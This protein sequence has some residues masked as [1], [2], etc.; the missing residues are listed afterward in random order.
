[1]AHFGDYLRKPEYLFRPSQVG[2]RIVRALR[3]TPA[4]ATVSL[5]WGTPITIRPGEVIGRAIWTTGVYDLAVTET[6][7]RLI[8]RDETVV[9]AGANIG[10]MTSLMAR[11]AGPRG[12]VLAFEPHPDVFRDL[13]ENA[14]RWRES[15]G[16]EQIRLVRAALGRQSGP[17]TLN[18]GP[19]FLSNRGTARLAVPENEAVSPR[20]GRRFD[21]DVV[22]L[23]EAVAGTRPAVLKIDVEGH[24]VAVLEGAARLLES[25]TIRDI[26]F[27]DHDTV[28]CPTGAHLGRYGYSVFRLAKGFIGPVL[29]SSSSILGARDFAAPS[30]LAT[31]DP[32]RA[33]SRLRPKGWRSLS[34]RSG[35]ARGR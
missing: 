28:T 19:D 9:D 34:P 8:D 25:G 27:E 2:R 17:A 22:T 23:D 10:Y 1:M 31:R 7:W 33:L 24:E 12:M 3:S 18:E 5:P 32:V 6:L 26:I 29:S 21:V 30:F 13:E 15:D 35:P 14:G 20:V 4:T 16:L 11:R